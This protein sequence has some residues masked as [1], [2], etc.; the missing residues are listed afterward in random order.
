MEQCAYSIPWRLKEKM[1]AI[2]GLL[3]L[4]ALELRYNELD[5]AV[6][7]LRLLASEGR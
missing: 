3:A 2:D 6:E 4:G 7:R 5:W 1:Q